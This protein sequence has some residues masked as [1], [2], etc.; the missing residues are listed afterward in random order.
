GRRG[1][2][3]F[4]RFWKTLR[5]SRLLRLPVLLIILLTFCNVPV[6]VVY[7]RK[8]LEIP[9]DVISVFTLFA[10]IG[11]VVT[12][13]LW[14]RIAD[15]IGFRSM[16]MGLLMAI[17]SAPLQLLL[18]PAGA[19]ADIPSRDL[20]THGVLM[21]IGLLAGGVMAGV[22]I[23]MTSIQ[24]YYTSS[25]DSLESMNIYQVVLTLATAGV[26]LWGG[27][28]IEDLALP[29]G[30]HPLAGG[31]AWIDWFK[32]YLVVVVPLLQLAML[33]LVS[34]LPDART[35][36]GIS[37]FFGAL[38]GSPVQSMVRQRNVYHRDEEKRTELA[39]WLGRSPNPIN[40]EAR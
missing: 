33:F 8:V 19:D 6:Y 31:L 18:A 25:R 10:S 36:F 7:L 9:S 34:R 29:G 15:A 3:G 30:T 32:G 2:A 26:S 13:F 35:H 23:G 24:H 39:Q 11:G 21:L 27:F 22:G 16:L 4:V 20:L 40:I 38:V 5:T 1:T 37:D 28:L 12:F 17:L 14:G